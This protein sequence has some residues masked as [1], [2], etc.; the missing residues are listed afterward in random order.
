[1]HVF[2]G[3]RTCGLL[4]VSIYS[5][6]VAPLSSK[7]SFLKLYFILKKSQV[8]GINF[9]KLIQRTKTVVCCT[10]IV[11]TSKPPE[12]LGERLGYRGY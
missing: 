11:F 12:N 3:F 2:A 4:C 8:G 6:C 10:T 5:N 7:V 9:G 1:M